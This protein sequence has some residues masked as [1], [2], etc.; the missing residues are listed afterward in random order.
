MGALDKLLKELAAVKAKALADGLRPIASIVADP[1]VA[2]ALALD[3]PEEDDDDKPPVCTRTLVSNV[4]TPYMRAVQNL[5]RQLLEARF[6]KDMG[7]TCPPAPREWLIEAMTRKVQTEAF[8]QYEGELPVT[9]REN[10]RRFDMTI[11]RNLR[12]RS[13]HPERYTYDEAL[14]EDDEPDREDRKFDATM[15]A[16]AKVPNPF[17]RGKAM[18]VFALIEQHPNGIQYNGLVLLLKTMWDCAQFIAEKKAQKAFTKW[19]D[20]GLVELV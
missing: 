17:A 14:D 11:G 2:V 13:K 7:F 9:T 19:V 4:V 6:T 3:Q 15:K 8:M 16:K 10:N 18:L 20:E 1:R 12:T 5:P